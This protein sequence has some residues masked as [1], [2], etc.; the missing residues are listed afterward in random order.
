MIG[1]CFDGENVLKSPT[2]RLLV[3]REQLTMSKIK[4]W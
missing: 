1:W 4:I 2:T 3:D